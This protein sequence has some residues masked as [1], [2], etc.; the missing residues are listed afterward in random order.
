MIIYLKEIFSDFLDCTFAFN[1]KEALSKIEEQSFEIIISDLKMP[2]M[3]GIEFKEALNKKAA[4]KN[5]PFIFIDFR[6]YK[7]ISA[8]FLKF[9]INLSCI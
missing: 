6:F 2:V 9:L 8:N 1:G 5:I 4:S 7:L 3:N